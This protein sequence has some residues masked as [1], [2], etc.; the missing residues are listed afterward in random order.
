MR[1]RNCAA[2]G[3]LVALAATGCGAAPS[4]HA[5]LKANDVSGAGVKAGKQAVPGSPDLKL[6]V[7]PASGAPGT[8]VRITATGC[9][10]ATGTNHAVSYNAADRSAG[11]NPNAVRSIAATLSGGTLTASYTVANRDR[12][13]AHGRFYVQCGASVVS[14]PFTVTR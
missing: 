2:A 14:A 6:T 7:T 8:V 9:V 11:R 5:T 12:G 13:A 3:A 1:L 10:D 4:T